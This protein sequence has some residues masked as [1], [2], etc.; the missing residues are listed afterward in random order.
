MRENR[1]N[2]INMSLLR[3]SRVFEVCMKKVKTLKPE[4]R[5]VL[6]PK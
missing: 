4:K 3:S 5:C 1:T 6:F 2:A